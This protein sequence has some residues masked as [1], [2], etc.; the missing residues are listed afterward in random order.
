VHYQE[1]RKRSIGKRILGAAIAIPALVSTVISFL[2]MVYFRLDDG[3]QFGAALA[4]PFK[5][6]VYWIYE[7]TQLLGFFWD[8]S[9]VPDQFNLLDIQNLYALIIYSGIFVGAALYA[10]GRK[11][12]ARLAVINEKIEDQLIE[13]SVKGA[14]GRSREE[15]E[16]TTAIPSNSVFAQAHQ[17]Y[18][19]PVIVG[20]IVAAV[21]AIIGI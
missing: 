16:K 10:S 1:A 3:T 6:A 7:Q 4:R 12:A 8:H 2:K 11:M 18:L 17:L 9:P 5:Q 15:I 20:V 14:N 21:V 19:A 13:E